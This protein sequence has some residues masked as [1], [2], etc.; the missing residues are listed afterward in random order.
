MKIWPKTIAIA[1]VAFTLSSVGLSSSSAEHHH[2]EA[3]I[4]QTSNIVQTPSFDNDALVS[5]V[6][7]CAL[8]CIFCI[9]TFAAFR[10]VNTKAIA[11]KITLAKITFLDHRNFSKFLNSDYKPSRGLILRM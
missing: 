3:A 9:L 8:A 5:T 11:E 2:T 7:Q 10:R 4:S 1:L 6:E